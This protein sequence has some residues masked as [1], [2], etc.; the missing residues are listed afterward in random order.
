[1]E[2]WSYKACFWL[3]RKWGKI[4]NSIERE[5][6]SKVSR[7]WKCQKVLN[8]EFKFLFISQ[9]RVDTWQH[10]EGLLKTS[11]IQKPKIWCQKQHFHMR[12]SHFTQALVVLHG[13]FSSFCM[14]VW[15]SKVSGSNMFEAF[16]NQFRAT[17]EISH[18]H[19]YT[20]LSLL[21]IFLF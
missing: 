15:N 12:S 9:G 1:M 11:K 3:M 4:E 5:R 13:H 8:K 14:V 20:L 6:V 18:E 7:K 16:L 17:C 19:V 10:F 21:H 2:I